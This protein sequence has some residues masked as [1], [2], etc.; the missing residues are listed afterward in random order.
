MTRGS[1]PEACSVGTSGTASR[2][3]GQPDRCLH[4]HQ[5]QVIHVLVIQVVALNQQ[6]FLLTSSAPAAEL[7]PHLSPGSVPTCCRALNQA[8]GRCIRHRLDYGAILLIDE[9]FQQPRNQLNLSR[10]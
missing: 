8:I 6:A 3:S 4:A 9:R 7:R 2:R 1:A 10:W 5:N